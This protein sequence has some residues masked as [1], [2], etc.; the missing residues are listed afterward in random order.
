MSWIDCVV[1]NDYQIFDE[2]PYQIRRKSN[3][4]IVKEFI[5]NTVG[6]VCCNLNGRRRYKHRIIAT[7][8]IPNPDNLPQVDHINKVRTDNRIDNLRWVSCSTNNRNKTTCGVY[9]YNYV[10]KISDNSFEFTEYGNHQ[11]EHYYYDV[12]VDKFYYYNG[13]QFRELKVCEHTTGALLVYTIDVNNK[14]VAIRLN[15]FKKL[16]NIPI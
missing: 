10:D 16:Y 5:D 1:D 15:K 7:Q 11:F 9:M 6:Y 12:D 14:P 3:K 13:V 2:E 8:F 4:R